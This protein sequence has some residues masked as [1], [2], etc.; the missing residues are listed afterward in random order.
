[1]KKRFPVFCIFFVLWFCL[2]P[3]A[4]SAPEGEIN[5]V[6]GYVSAVGYGAAAKGNMAQSKPMARRAAI[7]D[8]YRNLLE[9]IKGVK[10]DST[11]TVE[12]FMVNQ[13][14]IKTQIDGVVKG[15]KITKESYEAQQD[16]SLMA[17]VEMRVCISGCP[18]T[19]SI[20]QALNI[21]PVNNAPSIPQKGLPEVALANAPPPPKEYKIVYDTTRP[22]TGIVFNLE[23][24]V[25]QRVLL[26]VVVAEEL[27][28]SL[29]TVYS[30]KSVNPAVIRTYGTVRYADSL[31]QAR[32]NPH[33]GNNV[34]I[35]PASG[36]TKE[37]MI[38]I[39]GEAARLIKETMAH[40][41]DYLSEAKVIVSNQ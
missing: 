17:N 26:P 5:W 4:Y 6:G 25:F 23:G 30:A 19:M 13:D 31:D 35:I 8:A 33:L 7:S 28:D 32:N 37:N 15:A 3:L 2:T 41:N 16:G 10:V 9:I 36:I 29:V 24:R 20:I 18:G 22:V 27:G 21:E 1:M 14:L 40:G 38:I 34:M 12:N 11:T 39:K